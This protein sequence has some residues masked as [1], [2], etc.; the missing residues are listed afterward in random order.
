M[1]KAINWVRVNKV[2]IQN[3]VCTIGDDKFYQFQYIKVFW[4]ILNYPN[5]EIVL[6]KVKFD[7]NQRDTGNKHF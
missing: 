2:K 7:Q 1:K 6:R 4:L 5:L 3:P